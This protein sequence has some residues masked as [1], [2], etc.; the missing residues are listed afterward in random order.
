MREFRGGAQTGDL[1]FRLRAAFRRHQL[2]GSFLRGRS[3]YLS[4]KYCAVI[5]SAQ[6]L[7]QQKSID[8]A[9][10]P[11][12]PSLRFTHALLTSEPT[13]YAIATLQVHRY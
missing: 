11:R 8:N 5:G 13:F 10:F 6:P 9:A 12:F 7:P 2:D 1:T 4:K 3:R